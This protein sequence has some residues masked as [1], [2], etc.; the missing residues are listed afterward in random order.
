[1]AMALRVIVPPHPLL[2]HWL[3]VLR[4]PQTPQPLVSTALTELGRWLT[5]EALR[6][7]LPQREISLDA[8]GASCRGQVVDASVPL[9][10][11]SAV[12]GG[13][14]LWQGGHSVL[15][16]AQWGHIA[17]AGGTLSLCSLPASISAQTGVLIYWSQLA[18]PEPL[19]VLLD[20][21]AAQD[22][23][24]ARLRLITTIAAAPAL[25]AIG[26]R[27]GSLSIYTAAID[28]DLDELGR[29]HPGVG[30][31]DHRLIG[32]NQAH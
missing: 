7:W 3:T 15:P 10:A 24:G 22:V 2:S 28:P 20:H 17:V 16:A 18:E 11:I 26:E 27:H 25:Q 29:I 32:F 5:Y 14:G 6:D 19:L 4:E 21:L 23:S 12:P 1:M 9:L 30:E 8:D 13:L 31:L